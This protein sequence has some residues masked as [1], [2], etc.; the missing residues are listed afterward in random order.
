MSVL[1]DGSGEDEEDTVRFLLDQGAK[2]NAEDK[3]WSSHFPS[4]S[5]TLLNHSTY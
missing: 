5:V 4:Q 1:M 2:I 3:V